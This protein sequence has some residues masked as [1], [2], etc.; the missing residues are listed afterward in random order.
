MW[1][2]GSCFVWGQEGDGIY[3]YLD[4]AVVTDPTL[5]GSIHVLPHFEVAA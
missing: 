2:P 4:R 5:H 1:L 3:Q